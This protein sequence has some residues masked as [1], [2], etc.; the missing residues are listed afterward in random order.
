MF[1][2][3]IILRNTIQMKNGSLLKLSSTKMDMAT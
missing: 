3:I 2:M 1:Q